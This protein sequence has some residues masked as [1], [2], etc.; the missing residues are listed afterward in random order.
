MLDA[1]CPTI[2][3]L[4]PFIDNKY[5]KLLKIKKDTQFSQTHMFASNADFNGM[6]YVTLQVSIKPRTY[7]V[8]CGNHNSHIYLTYTPDQQD[9]P[10]ETK[11]LQESEDQPA[12]DTTGKQ[13]KPL[14]GIKASPC[15]YNR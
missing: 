1:T 14:C 13:C 6:E 15:H 7:K 11:R 4:I 8:K 10:Q 3:H 5:N 12:S 9:L 2:S